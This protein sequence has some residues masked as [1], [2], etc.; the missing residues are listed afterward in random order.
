[1]KRK[2]MIITI[3]M[4]SLFL[5]IGA[6]LSAESI[7][8]WTEERIV[9]PFT[10]LDIETAGKVFITQG[11]TSSVTIIGR[12]RLREKIETK[13]YGGTL[14]IDTD[15]GFWGSRFYDTKDLEI[16]ITITDLTE[17]EFQGV[18]KV[19]GKDLELSTLEIEFEGVGEFFLSGTV[20]N[21]K[22]ESKGVGRLDLSELKGEHVTLSQQGI[23]DV[24]LN[25]S[26]F[27]SI[28][29]SGIGRVTYTGEVEDVEIRST[30]IG[31]V[32]RVD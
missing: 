22:V 5:I 16:Y 23:G 15:L 17:F 21:L 18:G 3:C 6:S 27:L 26:Q 9:A 11:T 10:K 28:K 19:E 8:S 2:G 24:A 31:G 12:E 29:A 14:Y 30:G 25:A 7:D 32:T 20:E 13:V 1:M 4:V